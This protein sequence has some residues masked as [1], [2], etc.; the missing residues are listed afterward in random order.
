VFQHEAPT[1]NASAMHHRLRRSALALALSAACAAQ[2]QQVQQLERVEP[3]VLWAGVGQN[4]GG[5]TQL[6]NGRMEFGAFHGVCLLMS[7]GRR[8]Q[9]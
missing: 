4:L 2:A 5:C 6:S 8:F 1:P 3:A 9:V 7:R